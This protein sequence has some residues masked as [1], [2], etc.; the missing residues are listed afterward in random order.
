MLKRRQINQNP[1]LYI[2]TSETKTETDDIPIGVEAPQPAAKPTTYENFTH[3]KQ[4]SSLVKCYL[5]QP[6]QPLDTIATESQTL[7]FS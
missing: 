5:Q 6:S 7:K 3:N 1:H 2:A 4:C